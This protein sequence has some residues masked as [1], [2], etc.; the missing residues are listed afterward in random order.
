MIWTVWQGGELVSLQKAGRDRVETFLSHH[1]DRH[2]LI[3]E[4]RMESLVQDIQA[5]GKAAERRHDQPE[6]VAYE[7]R[8]PE[9][10]AMQ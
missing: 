1:P 8:P 9:R 3:A 2:T 5:T 10:M 4:Q 7:A 6:T